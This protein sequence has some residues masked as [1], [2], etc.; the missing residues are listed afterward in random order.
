MKK[1]LLICVCFVTFLLCAAELCF[2]Q[3]ADRG[4]GDLSSN[5]PFACGT[6]EQIQ[7]AI[8]SGAKLDARDKVGATPL[9][10]AALRQ[11]PEIVAMLL[12]A[13][14]KVDD[15][16]YDGETPLFYAV[17]NDDPAVITIL[18]NAGAKID[19][20]NLVGKTP[21]MW[22]ASNSSNPD[23]ILALLKAGADAKLK[24]NDEKTAFDYVT[25]NESLKGTA[26]FKA[27]PALAGGDKPQTSPL[28]A[29]GSETALAN[30][31]PIPLA[32][33]KIDGNFDR[34]NA[35]AP[36]II[37]KGSNGNMHFD[38]VF[39]AHDEKD[40]FIRI[41]I[42]DATRPSFVH[43]VNFQTTSCSY[44]IEI[45]NGQRTV[46]ANIFTWYDP[47]V[48]YSRNVVHFCAELDLCNAG[49]WAKVADGE[50]YM[51]GSS[52]EASFPLETFCN[53]LN[54]RSVGGDLVSV[55]ARAGYIGTRQWILKG[56]PVETTDSTE[57]IL[58]PRGN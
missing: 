17:W 9:M 31:D 4:N 28:A 11:P 56:N 27:L 46:L 3:E 57:L 50:F 51:K 12:G 45:T 30:G 55:R 36:A 35:T 2:S 58:S 16:D 20:R 6:R 41:D 39:L 49:K 13:G 38:K 44:C 15:E 42:K 54:L 18:L 24:S 33:I 52:V 34:W 23:V 43:P 1:D 21:L 22:A 25:D 29:P 26:A 32:S 37:G 19:K 10:N 7:R 53:S 14:A 8:Q 40:L 47:T 5:D 48:G